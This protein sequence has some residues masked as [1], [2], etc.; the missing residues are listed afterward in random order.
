MQEKKMSVILLEKKILPKKTI[1]FDF[2]SA[3][4]KITIFAK[5][6]KNTEI[7][8]F[9]LIEIEFSRGRNSNFLRCAT[10][11]KIFHNFSENFSTFQN[12][13]LFLKIL[14]KIAHEKLIFE[15]FAEI[16]LIF[17]NFSAEFS[18]QFL[19]FFKIKILQFE[20][21]FPKIENE[22]ISDSTK[23]TVIF[24]LKNGISVAQKFFKKIPE[25]N[26]AE[27]EK[28]LQKNFEF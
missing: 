20:G 4:G 7:D 5:N 1:I 11:K 25:K 28:I 2:F 3:S 27:I 18:R 23:K 19:L 21:I 26:F 16:I 9:R 10:A 15:N 22:K 24:F 8:F 17:E 13:F 14:K 6:L 12:G